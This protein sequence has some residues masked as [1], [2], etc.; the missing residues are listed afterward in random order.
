M[1][2][3]KILL[4]PIA[5]I[6]VF[7]GLYV[8]AAVLYPGGSQF[9]PAGV[10]FSFKHNY[11]C[12]LLNEHSID[13]KINPAQPFALAGMI[14]LALSLATFWYVLPGL[15]STGAIPANAVKASGILAMIP[16]LF[17]ASERH[18]TMMF[19]S[20]LLAAIALTGTLIALYKAQWNKLFWF[21]IL[22][23]IAILLNNILYHSTD[24]IRYL[25]V[26]QKISFI[27]FFGWICVISIKLYK[28]PDAKL[29]GK[30]YKNQQ[31]PGIALK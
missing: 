8:T 6:V 13:G 17:I 15:L 5:G 23:V 29:S 2:R 30:A 10:G 21:G 31:P 11:W 3:N 9:D 22:N 14:A 7:A 20:G 24:L 18:D 25:P 28:L 4:L 16:A 19:V 26:I 12:N 27:L 1:I